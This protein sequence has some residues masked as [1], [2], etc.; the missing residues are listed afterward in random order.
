MNDFNSRK[1]D[2]IHMSVLTSSRSSS[3]VHEEDSWYT[4]NKDYIW[5]HLF[6]GLLIPIILTAIMYLYLNEEIS[7]ELLPDNIPRD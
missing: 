7:P 3:C 4:R 5:R 2:I 6:C 1:S